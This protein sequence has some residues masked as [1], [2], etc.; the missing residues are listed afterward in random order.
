MISNERSCV[1]FPTYFE[2]NIMSVVSFSTSP[3]ELAISGVTG[4]PLCYLVN[5]VRHSGQKIDISSSK[6]YYVPEIDRF[7]SHRGSY[8]KVLTVNATGTYNFNK[9]L[10]LGSYQFRPSACFLHEEAYGT[11][12]G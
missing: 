10:P 1:C 6:Y 4:R 5:T 8:A 12:R 3:V 9:K 7:V 2:R 11:F